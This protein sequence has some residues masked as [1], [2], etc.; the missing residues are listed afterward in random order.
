MKC[1]RIDICAFIQTRVKFKIKCIY[2][3]RIYF[4]KYIEHSILWIENWIF[5]KFQCC[6]YFPL[7]IRQFTFMQPTRTF[8]PVLSFEFKWYDRTAIGVPGDR[9]TSLKAKNNSCIYLIYH[10]CVDSLQVSGGW[11]PFWFLR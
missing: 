1:T 11:R 8:L 9:D 3:A 10:A 7:A 2:N 6:Q 5:Y 4:M